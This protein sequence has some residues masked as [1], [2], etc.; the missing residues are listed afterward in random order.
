MIT[1]K[2]LRKNYFSKGCRFRRMEGAFFSFSVFQELN[3]SFL[4]FF[5]REK[6]FW[7]RRFYENTLGVFFLCAISVIVL[8]VLAFRSFKFN[9][10]FSCFIISQSSI[11]CHNR[12]R[13]LNYSFN[14]FI[15]KCSSILRFSRWEK[16]G[17]STTIDDFNLRSFIHR[18]LFSSKRLSF[19]AESVL[20]DWISAYIK[21]IAR[22]NSE[23]F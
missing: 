7:F 16:S 22:G 4:L 18:R 11:H 3:V 1:E 6:T 13:I 14:V 23:K 21:V 19:L 15:A 17:I 12:L 8:L 9:S 10:W 20:I 2:I 5:F